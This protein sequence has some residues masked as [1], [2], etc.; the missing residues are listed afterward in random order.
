MAQDARGSELRPGD[1]VLVRFRILEVS[2]REDGGNVILETAI[3]MYPSQAKSQISLNGRQV[4]VLWGPGYQNLLDEGK[5]PFTAF[6]ESL[7]GEQ[8]KHE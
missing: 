2:A 7:Q 3:P 1:V 4:E 8:N 5:P 6:L